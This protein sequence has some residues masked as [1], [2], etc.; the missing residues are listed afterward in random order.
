MK[1]SCTHPLTHWFSYYTYRYFA[2]MADARVQIRVVPLQSE[3]RQTI[4]IKRQQ[5]PCK[6]T[7]MGTDFIPRPRDPDHLSSTVIHGSRRGSSEAN[8]K[9][10]R[11]SGGLFGIGQSK[12]SE[13]EKYG[14][15]VAMVS[16]GKKRVSLRDPIEIVL[17]NGI[18][19]K[20]LKKFAAVHDILLLKKF[21]RTIW[22]LFLTASLITGLYT[23]VYLTSGWDPMSRIGGIK[24]ALVMNDIGS[25]NKGPGQNLGN[26]GAEILEGIMTVDETATLL[27]WVYYENLSMRELV[28]MV[29]RGDVFMGVFIGHDFSNNI[30]SSI[31]TSKSPS[32]GFCKSSA[33]IV[34]DEGVQ[35]SSQRIILSTIEEI[36]KEIEDLFLLKMIKFVMA[37]NGTVHVDPHLFKHGLPLLQTNLHPVPLVGMGIFVSIAPLVLWIGSSISVSMIATFIHTNLQEMQDLHLETVVPTHQ[38]RNWIRNKFATKFLPPGRIVGSVIALVLICTILNSTILT[39][40]FV[41]LPGCTLNVAAFYLWAWCWFMSMTFHFIL[42]MFVSVLG[43]GSGAT[44]GSIF[45]LLQMSSNQASIVLDLMPG[46]YRIGSG[47]PMFHAVRGIKYLV[48]GS[49]ERHFVMSAC[50]LGAWLV[51]SFVVSCIFIMGQIK[52]FKVT[53]LNGLFG[54]MSGLRL[55]NPDAFLG[56]YAALGGF[57]GFGGHDN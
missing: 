14:E 10:G 16:N 47:F 33:E 54:D 20:E 28:N 37:A 30:S 52:Q 26:I 29:T 51:G 46:V 3:K 49:L 7:T 43:Q 15:T 35:S 57:G 56:D 27:D 18:K 44:A 1:Q 13:D 11:D 5:T 21:K 19:D 9:S 50:V 41:F 24:V 6:N 48:F 42:A 45:L 4:G 12:D 40:I 22:G 25:T 8:P 53:Y 17:G 2:S 38:H 39:L 36:W 23:T 34:W 55:A 32:P 31:S